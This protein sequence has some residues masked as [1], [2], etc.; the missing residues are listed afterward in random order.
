M[1][2]HSLLHLADTVEELGPL[3]VYSL[4]HF[5]DKNGYILKLIH[6]NNNQ[7]ISHQLATAISSSQFVS[8]FCEK[9]ID[10]TSTEKKFL[11]TCSGIKNRQNFFITEFVSGIGPLKC[12]KPTKVEN[13][14]FLEKTFLVV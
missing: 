1:N 5:E 8:L 3:Y 11:D 14:L 7:N 4:F 10:K 13:N 6:N 12:Y 2:V 9:M